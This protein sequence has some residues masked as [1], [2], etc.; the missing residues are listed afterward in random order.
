MGGEVE[1]LAARVPDQN[2][3]TRLRLFTE[4]VDVSRDR[5]PPA[6]DRIRVAVRQPPHVG[7]QQHAFNVFV[8]VESREVAR[9]LGDRDGGGAGGQS[10]GPHRRPEGLKQHHASEPW[11]GVLETHRRPEQRRCRLA[12]AALGESDHA[13]HSRCLSPRQRV[14]QVRQ[15]LVEKRLRSVR[16]PGGQ[17][18]VRGEQQPQR[19]ALWLWRQLRGT[20]EQARSRG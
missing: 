11:I 18:G 17:L 10:A 3:P 6:V 20:L 5:T 16:G 14:A 19:P 12:A 15:A 2:A 9:G 1:Q 8:P 4:V 13:L 7:S